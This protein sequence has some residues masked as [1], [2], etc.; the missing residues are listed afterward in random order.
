MKSLL[1]TDYS[2]KPKSLDA[3][4]YIIVSFH[5]LRIKQKFSR[6]CENMVMNESKK[7]IYTII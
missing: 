5:W 3:Q 6:V 7:T 4:I 2:K 1:E